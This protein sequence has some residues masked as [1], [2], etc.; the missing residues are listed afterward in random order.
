MVEMIATRDAYGK[1]LIELGEKNPNIVVLD[2]DLS[3]STKTEE[4]SKRFPERFF[5]IGIAEANM[6]GIAAGLASCGKI[7]FA[8]SFAI[9]AT[10]RAWEQIRNTI[11]FSA[12]PVKIVGTHGGVSV[13]AD[14]CSHQ[15]IEDFAIM[16]SIPTMTVIAPCDGPEARRAVL[17]AAEHPGP[18][19]LRMGRAK[20]P[21]ITPPSGE[22]TIGKGIVLRDGDDVTLVG[23]DAM[24]GE[25]LA[26]AQSLAGEGIDAAVIDMHTLKPVDAELLERYA[27]KTGAFVTAEQHVLQG[28][29][30]SAVAEALA[31]S[32]AAPVEML[33][34]DNVFG[35]SG[36]PDILFEHYR[37]TA[38]HIALAARR[39]IARKRS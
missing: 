27:R 26:A 9:F 17:A 19:Y 33:G 22:F 28:G 21:T 5:N 10:G 11:A 36:E 38:K 32:A 37:L 16:R 14:G 4:F 30:G 2:A 15:A 34:L 24:V 39:A 23:C 13:G 8:S 12:L 1:A 35:Q 18:V 25:C 7:P 20:V 31:R 3:K 6:M 29:L